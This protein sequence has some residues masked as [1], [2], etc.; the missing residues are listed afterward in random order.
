MVAD[1]SKRRNKKYGIRHGR[2]L[3]YMKCSWALKTFAFLNPEAMTTDTM[4]MSEVDIHQKPLKIQRTPKDLVPV[5]DLSEIFMESSF[6]QIDFEKQYSS[7]YFIRLEVLRDSIMQAARLKWIESGKVKAANLVGHVK[8]YKGNDGDIIL[9]GVLFKDMSLKPNVL[10]DIQNNL[11]I[12]DQ[13]MDSRSVDEIAHKLAEKDTLFLEDME[14]RL[15]LVFPDRSVVDS[16]TTGVVVAV[17]GA[18]N[19]QGFF[20]VK[21]FALP[22]YL[23]PD[24]LPVSER[25]PAY[26]G[27]LSGLRIGS[28]A[29]NP[30]ALQM[31]RDFVMGLSGGVH[32]RELASKIARI[33]V[34]GDTLFVSAEKDST[35]SA[36]A[37]AD[38]FLSELASVVPLDVM[39]GPRDP[40]NYCLPQQ[41][42]HSGLFPEARRYGNMTVRMNPFKAKVG[43]MVILGT[44]GQ[45]VSDVFQYTNAESGMDALALIGQSRYLAP[46]A[47]D[48]LACY[49]FTIKDPLVLSASNGPVPHLLFAG[50]QVQ[51]ETK[52]VA[53]GHLRLACVADFSVKPSML[54]VNINDLSDTRVISFD[55]PDSV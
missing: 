19:T 32:E 51:T 39:S 20:E 40:V 28:T 24:A 41:P 48:T 29:T 50:N 14:A 33:V 12:S 38:I 49:P 8:S 6:G 55:T 22:G 7:A 31:L 3:R 42:L 27:F 45:N 13:F 36:L 4:D 47:P 35:G 23:Q 54:L 18:V 10:S 53:N 9:V 11:R 21:D 16:L 1:N 44:S 46:T 15:Q 30:L 37:E 17:L 5:E 2:F 43:E 52:L 25:E 26:I 34:A